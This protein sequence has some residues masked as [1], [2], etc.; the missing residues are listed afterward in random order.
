MGI[1]DHQVSHR[2]LEMLDTAKDYFKVLDK[3]R[4][5]QES[6]SADLIELKERLTDL[7]HK[8]AHNPAYQA[9]LEL[10]GALALGLEELR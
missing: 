10:H 2:Y 5:A 7:S 4:K 1:E 3:A 9:Y 6:N 8:Y